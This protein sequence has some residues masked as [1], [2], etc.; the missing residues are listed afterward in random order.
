MSDAPLLHSIEEAKP[1]DATDAQWD[2]AMRGLRAFLARGRADE[3]L[4]LGWPHNELFAVPPVWANVALF[5]TGLLI[6]DR[7]VTEVTGSRKST[8]ASFTRRV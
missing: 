6:G 1:P 3:A 5:G 7:E 2:A 4:S 8:I